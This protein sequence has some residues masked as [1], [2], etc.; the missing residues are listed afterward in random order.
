M[1][2]SLN[3]CFK[4]M[5]CAGDSAKNDDELP[6]PESK[7]SPGKHRWSFQKRSAMHHVPSNNV[8]S[9]SMPIMNN[10][11]NQAAAADTVNSEKASVSQKAT[12][13]EQTN[14]I[15]T[16]PLDVVPSGE[17]EQVTDKSTVKVDYNIREDVAVVVQASIRGYLA[18][19]ELEKI[20]NVVKLQAAIRRYLV[21]RQAVGTL[22]CMLAIVKIQQLIRAHLS[23]RSTKFT[24]KEKLNEEMKAVKVKSFEM[25]LS[26]TPPVIRILA[27]N[28]FANQLLKSTLE[29]KPIHISCN[30]LRPDSGWIWLERWMALTSSDRKKVI[31]KQDDLGEGI[32]TDLDAYEVNNKLQVAQEH[33]SSDSKF[34]PSDPA[35]PADVEV[36]LMTNSSEKIEVDVPV[37]IQEQCSNSPVQNDQVDSYIKET[38]SIEK[39]EYTTGTLVEESSDSIQ[40]QILL[41]SDVVSEFALDG[42]SNKPDYS[43]ETNKNAAKKEFHETPEMEIGQVVI[44]SRKSRNPGFAAVQA[45]FEE[46]SSASSS[47]RSLNHA[48]KDSKSDSKSVQ[49]Q[50][51]SNLEEIG[52]TKSVNFQVG[53]K[54]KEVRLG[55]NLTGHTPI[56]PVDTL[57]HR[58][59][60]STT[61]IPDRSEAGLSEI[62]PEIRTSNG[63]F[64]IVGSST[65]LNNGEMAFETDDLSSDSNEIQWQTMAKSSESATRSIN[66]AEPVQLKKQSAES[67][68][69][70]TQVVDSAKVPQV[71]RSS[72]EGSPRSHI[73]VPES[74]GTPSSQISIDAKS[75]KA[76]N[77]IPVRKRRS[78][79]LVNSSPTNSKNDSGAQTSGEFLKKETKSAK[80]RNSFSM[81]KTDHVDHE[82]QT[83]NGNLLPSYMQ[84]TESAR[85]KVNTSI[86]QKSSLDMHH[87]KDNHIK[88][89]HSLPNGDGKQ[90]SSPRMQRSTSQAQQNM[91][92]N[93]IPSPPNSSGNISA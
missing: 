79:L 87:D 31:L 15:S 53:T 69:S 10:K 73:I 2:R 9:E 7:T 37:S 43:E 49:S 57:E 27:S 84:P 42:N 17:S 40:S 93:G 78:Q 38:M 74:H 30:P 67:I 72:Q 91:K 59:D 61:S 18:K 32:N 88:K 20:K 6:Q 85:A 24:A 86:S 77:N 56:N 76:E 64:C 63:K 14:E 4:I 5:S 25:K 12:V 3:S 50:L 41:S 62:V 89:R 11:Q 92:G 47:N 39:E 8:I 68:S 55:E 52:E 26:K 66:T 16:L 1:G 22:R 34:A 19:R 48:S 75:I 54:F 90:G 46:L 44:E 83:S 21:R 36:D 45:K 13:A 81:V 23:F 58:K 82:H 80:R 29:T 60:I 28:A 33:V 70:N 35:G 51:G 71:S 65:N